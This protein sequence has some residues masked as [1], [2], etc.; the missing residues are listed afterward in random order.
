MAAIS[1][2]L[3]ESSSNQQI[4]SNDIQAILIKTNNQI[5]KIEDMFFAL[6]TGYIKQITPNSQKLLDDYDKRTNPKYTNR[7]RTITT[8]SNYGKVLRNGYLIK[9]GHVR[10]SWK[11]RLFI[12]TTDGYLRYYD[13]KQRLLNEIDLATAQFVSVETEHSHYNKPFV[14]TV[15]V[16]N[17]EFIFA[18]ENENVR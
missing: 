9:Q 6:N 12:L 1:K 14:F 5:K 7:N 17:R 13:T 15:K 18:A 2:K 8:S 10:K 3:K 16:P 4:K 11:K